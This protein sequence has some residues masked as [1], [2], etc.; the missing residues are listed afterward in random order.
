M[1]IMN[2]TSFSFLDLKGAFINLLELG[3]AELKKDTDHYSISVFRRD[4]I[5]VA[6]TQGMQNEIPCVCVNRIDDSESDQF[7]GETVDSSE[8]GVEQ[9]GRFFKETFELRV[10]SFSAQERDDIY[11]KL[12]YIILA[13]K[14][15]FIEDEGGYIVRM[16]SGVDEADHNF[17]PGK[18]MFWGTMH[19]SATNG[20][21]LND[22][23]P[24]ESVSEVDVE[25]SDVQFDEQLI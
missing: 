11:S 16:E 8:V 1:S 6:G 19:V 2:N 23:T 13:G 24:Y 25:N 9:H 5:F 3:F 20:Y 18:P 12:K 10:W 7:I 22:T 21:L 14:K 4:P 17:L 15:Q